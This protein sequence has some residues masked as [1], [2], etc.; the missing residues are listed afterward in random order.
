MFKERL[1][2]FK[3]NMTR[4]D[5]QNNKKKVE[6]LVIGILIIIITV[7]AINTILGDNKDE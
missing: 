1:E 7:I 5:N 2:R 6:N 4:S 3:D